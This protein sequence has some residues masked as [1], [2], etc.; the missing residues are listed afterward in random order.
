MGQNFVDDKDVVLLGCPYALNGFAFGKVWD[1]YENNKGEYFN[2]GETTSIVPMITQRW[3][4]CD[5]FGRK[6]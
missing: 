6:G 5:F 4:S 3:I 1:T 2:N